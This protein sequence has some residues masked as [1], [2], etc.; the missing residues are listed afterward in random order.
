MLSPADVTLYRD[1]GYLV[2][3][4]VLDRATLEAAR[5]EMARLLEGARGHDPHRSL[6]SR[7]GASRGRDHHADGY[8]CGAID[9]A[10]IRDEMARAVPA[11]VRMPLPPARHQGSI[12]ENQSDAARRYFQITD[13]P[14]RTSR[15]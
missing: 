2:V 15:T 9:P 3:P 11:P 12:Y 4:D 5:A 7:A 10:A 13:E 1:R 6:R 8:F 14:T